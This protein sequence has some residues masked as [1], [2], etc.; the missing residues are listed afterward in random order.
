MELRLVQ[1]FP[2]AKARAFSNPSGTAEVV[3][4][5]KPFMTVVSF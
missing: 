1:L 2:Q 4:F 5:A 3:P